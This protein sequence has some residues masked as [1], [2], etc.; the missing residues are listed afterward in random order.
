MFSGYE[1]KTRA[2]GGCFALF[3]VNK[4]WI[5]ETKLF[6][7][8]DWM[9]DFLPTIFYNVFWKC[10]HCFTCTYICT[11]EEKRAFILSQCNRVTKTKTQSRRKKSK[12]F[13]SLQ[14]PVSS[15]F[16]HFPD[17]CRHEKQEGALKMSGHWNQ[18]IFCLALSLF[19]SKGANGLAITAENG[20]F[21][22]HSSLFF[23]PKRAPRSLL[24]SSKVQGNKL[25]LFEWERKRTKLQP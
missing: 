13:R 1:N 15:P 16:S 4:W 17:F 8:F 14:Y 9:W 19:L 25:C 10:N 21:G 24:P 6:L 7:D 23:S 2:E 5:K 12:P 11:W 3:E 22:S 18:N 20:A